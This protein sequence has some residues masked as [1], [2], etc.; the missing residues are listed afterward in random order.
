MNAKLHVEIHQACS[1]HRKQKTQGLKLP[2]VL[3][4]QM[5]DMCD[6]EKTKVQFSCVHK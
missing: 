3:Q 6:G 5:Q 1:I 4:I 2:K